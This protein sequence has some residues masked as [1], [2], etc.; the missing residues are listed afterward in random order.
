M[1]KNILMIVNERG[2][3][4]ILLQK[5]DHCFLYIVNH[6]KMFPCFHEPNRPFMG[7]SL[8]RGFFNLLDYVTSAENFQIGDA[9]DTLYHNLCIVD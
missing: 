6:W 3:V 8:R 1:Q 2:M 4:F 5:Y 7:M 9:I